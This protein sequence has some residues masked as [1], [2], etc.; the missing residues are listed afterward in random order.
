MRLRLAR[1]LSLAFILPIAACSPDQTNTRSES[2]PTRSEGTANSVNGRANEAGDPS[3]SQPSIPIYTYEVVNSWPH[4]CQAFSQGLVFYNGFLFESTGQYG[5]SSLRKVD[6]STGK[7]LEKIK[8]PKEYFAEGIAVFQGKIYQLT[9]ESHK[10]FVYDLESFER[11]GEF[12]Y[13]GEGWGLTHDGHSLIMSDGTNR[14]R[15]LD[16]TNFHV[17][18]K[19]SVY[20][21]SL[22]LNELNEL[23]YIKGEIYANIWKTNRIVRIDPNS[24]KITGW[25]DLTGLL[26]SKD[27][28]E[29]TDVLNG[30][31]YDEGGDRLFVTGKL[32]PKIFEI[33]LKR[34]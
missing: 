24:G 14:I 31:A 23:E 13:D 9:W 10:G 3:T 28:C 7:I 5:S 19:I 16:P 11:E 33:R 2:Q 34:K 6:L 17:E 30:I 26:T 12:S 15:F 32:W 22:P 4:D 18:R 29:E 20:D 27:G 1:V 25:I 8:V 21:N